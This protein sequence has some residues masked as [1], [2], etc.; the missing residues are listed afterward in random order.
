[1]KVSRDAIIAANPTLDWRDVPNAPRPA[2]A[3]TDPATMDEVRVI[4][5]DWGHALARKPWRARDFN[6][7]PAEPLAEHLND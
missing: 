1:V 5:N 2:L 4:W 7:L 3:F 6:P